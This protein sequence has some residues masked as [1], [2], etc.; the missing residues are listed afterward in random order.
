M[1][2]LFLRRY[3]VVEIKFRQKPLSRIVENILRYF[4]RFDKKIMKVWSFAKLFKKV[5]NLHLSVEW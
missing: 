1:T 3:N 5:L 2:T 4:N